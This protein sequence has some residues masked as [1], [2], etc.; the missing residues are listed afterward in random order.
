MHPS[1][2]EAV[3]AGAHPPCWARAADVDLHQHRRA[4]GPAGHLGGQ[5]QPVDGLPQVHERRDL[6]H[7]VALQAPDPVP[8]VRARRIGRLAERLVL[9]EQLLG[10][11]LAEV[12]QAGVD[13][14]PHERRGLPLGDGD[15]ADSGRVAP[16]AAMRSRTPAD[17]L[18]D[19][20][21]HRHHAASIQATVAKRPGSWRAR[22]LYQRWSQAVQPDA[23]SRASTPTSASAARTARGGPAPGCRVVVTER[24]AVPKRST[25]SS[26]SGPAN[27]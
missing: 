23:S 10:V 13:R 21:E 24:T 15:E 4:R 22:W 17:G 7:L 11:A 27:S 5:R 12:G 18:L 20:V 26:S 8:A 6:P 16:A 9:V 25:T 3:R 2:T 1:T 14:R 19:V